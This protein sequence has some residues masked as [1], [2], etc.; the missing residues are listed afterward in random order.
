MFHSKTPI[1]LEELA[2]YAPSALATEKH[3]SR[4][5]KYGFQSPVEVI[6]SLQSEGF[7]IFSASES[8]TK[9]SDGYQKHMLRFRHAAAFSQ[10]A[11]VGGVVPELVMINAMDG[12]ACYKLMGGIFRFVCANGMVVADSLIQSIRIRHTVNL[13]QDVLEASVSIASQ[14]TDVLNTMD[15]WKALT[16]TTG[17]QSALA[18]AAHYLRFA[19]SEGHLNTAIRPEQLLQIRREED[20]GSDLWSTHNRIQENVIKG[21]LTARAVT[22]SG[23]RGRRVS[24]REVRE[25]STDVKLN[26]ALWTLSSELAKLKG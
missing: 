17:E 23:G 21:G 14:T 24:T 11:I 9:V 10:Q 20:R 13:V 12:S 18:T 8:N 15:S 16:L 5:D 6:R 26:Q 25:I 2:N 22:P 19:D 1:S 3:S 4:S 7:E